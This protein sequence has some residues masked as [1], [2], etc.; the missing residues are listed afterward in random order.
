[1]INDLNYREGLHFAL[2]AQLAAG[3]TRRQLG[4]VVR[5]IGIAWAVNQ[6]SPEPSWLVPFADMSPAGQEAAM[7][8]GDALFALGWRV[9][10]AQERP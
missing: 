9:A 7:L 3:V 2:E 1:M 6:P 5:E 4:E 8:I 10:V